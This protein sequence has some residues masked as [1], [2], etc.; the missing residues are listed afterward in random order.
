MNT[1][2][3]MDKQI[4]DLTH[5][6]STAQ[7]HS[8][9]FI[10]LMKHEP[11]QQQNHHRE[12]DDDEEEEEN[13][14]GNGINKDDIIPSYDFQPIRPLAS[15]SYDSAP[16]FGAAFSRPWN[17]D[18][19][20]KVTF[21]NCSFAFKPRFFLSLAFL[22]IWVSCVFD[23]LFVCWLVGCLLKFVVGI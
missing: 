10:D 15:S 19:N 18:S 11:P 17:S 5:G 20:S 2:P 23:H 21:P 8:K 4:M 6:S 9:D 12:E 16:N 7:Q 1:T 14:R 13:A 22:L 3:F